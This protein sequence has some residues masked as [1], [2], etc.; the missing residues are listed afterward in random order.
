MRIAGFHIDGFGTLCD[1]GIDD[2]SPGLVIISGPNEAGKSTL[3][4]FLTAMLFGF[5]A[6]RDNPRFRAP[7]RG[8]RHGG[9][10]TLAEGHGNES[11]G[12]RRQW[13]IER[14]TGPNKLV[15]IRR[16]DG[17]SASEEELRGAL[18]GADEA[19]FRAV[20]AVD[21]TDL[22][23]ADA[24][25]RDDVRELLFSASIVGQRR[26]AAR[27]MGNL[28]KQ[29]L[30]LARLRQGDAMA[31]RLLAE[32]EGVRRSLSEAS[33]EATGYPA[34]RAEL[35]R[36]ERELAQSHEDV[37]RNEHRTRDLDLLIRLWDVLE[38]KRKAEQ[39]LSCWEEPEPLSAWLETQASE[40]HSLKAACSGHLERVGRLDDLNNQRGGIE[41]SIRA[42]MGSLGPDWDRDRVCTSDGWIGLTDEGRRFR[43]SLGELEASWRTA[44]ALAKDADSAPELADLADEERA[45]PATVAP[46]APVSDP[47][48]QARLLGEL[49]KNLAEQRL[50]SAELQASGRRAGT[51]AG[52]L[53]ATSFASIGLVAFVIT[54]LSLIAALAPG[55]TAMRILC[56][57]LAAAGCVLL[58]LAVASRRRILVAVPAEK[59]GVEAAN[60]RVATR[61]AELAAS[62]GLPDSP[63]ESDVETVAETIEDARA[64]ERAL[65][66][67]RRRRTAALQ[68]RKSA[69]DSLQRASGKL[70]AERSSFAS[71]KAAHGLAPSLS[72]DGVLESLTALQTAWKD[73][74]ALDRVDARI[75]QLSGE[76]SEFETRLGKLSAGLGEL[77]GDGEPLETDPA[78]ALDQLCALL[79]ETVEL[80]AARTSLVQVVEDADAQLERSFGL[81]PQARRL[82]EELETGEVLAWQDEQAGLAAARPEARN[83]LEQLLRAH[84]DTSNE[85]RVIAGSGRVAELEQTRLEL[86][87]ELG[88]VLKSWAILGCARLLLERTLRRHEREHQPAVLARA[89]DRFAKVTGGRYTR[90]LPSV[91][92]DGGRETI[93][94]LSSLG[95]EIDASSLSRGSIEQLYLCLRLG[96]AETFAERSAALPLILDDVLVNFDP[97]RAVPVAEALA[98]TAEHHQVLFMTCHPHLEELVSSV[99]PHAQ[100]VRLERI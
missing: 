76:V 31:N 85:L 12:D 30:E 17:A 36:L 97:G 16:S 34:R 5:P 32:L 81:G 61:V 60:Q 77:G 38:R 9:Q 72:P 53:W 42:A 19:L 58:A 80:R 89:G 7:V 21:L 23:N 27:A 70:D 56:A 55:P 100:V 10:L 88:A 66:D 20:F 37:D 71:W 59:A 40:L 25:N 39:R 75:E 73:F 22:G 94:V 52:V 65:V 82:R 93:R 69:H 24:V 74:A 4:D 62:L 96:L 18:G 2:L 26:S 99:A 78:G 41:Q 49:R 43:T 57:V 28:Q 3:L 84:Q 90:L 48:Q 91:E 64:V 15:S 8:G 67:D 50:L 83:H 87:Q 13:R 98:E 6:R 11:D 79:A 33:Q 44:A 95:A 86:E 68:R 92:E 63:S 47:E 35:L 29:R 51:P 54:G 46:D 14:Y 45:V 1:L